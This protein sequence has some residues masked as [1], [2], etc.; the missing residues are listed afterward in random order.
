MNLEAVTAGEI[1]ISIKYV[2]E[3]EE[4]RFFKSKLADYL[5]AIVIVGSVIHL[6]QSLDSLPIPNSASRIFRHFRRGVVAQLPYSAISLN[7]LGVYSAVW[8]AS[9]LT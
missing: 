8:C 1:I 5:L 7:G 9:G 6:S 2:C 4:N 3:K